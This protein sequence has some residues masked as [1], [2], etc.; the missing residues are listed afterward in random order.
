MGKSDFTQISW[1]KMPKIRTKA[2]YQVVKILLVQVIKESYNF[3]WI[4]CTSCPF[5]VMELKRFGH[6]F[7]N[8]SLVAPVRGK[9]SR[10]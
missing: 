8:L 5:H 10:I 6:L 3:S 9:I 7:E 2:L 4:R 1:L